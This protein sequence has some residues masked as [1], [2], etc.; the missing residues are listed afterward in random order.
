MSQSVLRSQ[1]HILTHDMTFFCL[2]FIFKN[3]R[4]IQ[5]ISVENTE[6]IFYNK[7]CLKCH[8][9]KLLFSILDLIPFSYPACLFV[10]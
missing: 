8:L 3:K 9:R 7:F 2:P 1:S 5:Y 6:Y 4:Y 10:F